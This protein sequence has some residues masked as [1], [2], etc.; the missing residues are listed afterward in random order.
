MDKVNIKNTSTF[1]GHK[2]ARYA[3]GVL[4]T[5]SFLS[6]GSDRMLVKWS[7]KNKNEGIIVANIPETVFTI[8]LND[9]KDQC[10]CGTQN[11]NILILDLNKKKL[12]KIHLNYFLR[13]Y[14]THNASL[15]L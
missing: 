1:L 13:L 14:Y 4:S 9:N 11:G 5:D 7:Y 2:E 8:Q 3:L 12:I 15:F 10:L 6:A